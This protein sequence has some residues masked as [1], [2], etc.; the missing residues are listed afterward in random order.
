[1]KTQRHSRIGAGKLAQMGLLDDDAQRQAAELLD[2]VEADGLETVRLAFSDQHGILRGKT[3]V[4]SA[5][6]SAF[7]SGLGLPSTLLLK[8]TAHRTVFDV[9]SGRDDLDGLTLRGASDV[10]LVPDP[11]A[12]HKLDWA[13][14]SGLL[15]GDVVLRDGAPIP[16]A[17]RHVL[18]TAVERLAGTGHVAMMGLEVEFQVFERIDAR[19]DHGQATMPGAPVATRNTTQ[20]YQYLTETRYGEAEA[21]LDALRRAAEVMGLAPRSVEIEMGPSQY[22]FTFDASDPMEQADRFVLFRTMVK[23][24][25]HARGLHG[26]FMAKPGLPNAA[27]NGW[28]IHQSLVSA[29]DGVPAFM[30]EQDGIP[31]PAAEGWIAGLLEHAAASC[32][33][34]TP[35]VN[36]YKRYTPFQLAP[37]RIQ[38]GTDNRGAMIRALMF[39][40]DRAS[41]I[42]NRAPDSTANPHYALAAQILSGLDGL[43]RKAR[44]PA[45]TS[46]PYEGAALLPTSLGAAIDAFE[47]SPLFR[48]TLGEGFVSYLGH[49]KRAEWDRYLMTVSDWEQAEYFNLF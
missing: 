31:T 29:K 42:E 24:V 6:E 2:R 4:A 3:L 44:P 35:T 39:R 33:L 41:R 20:G 11:A 16:F 13:P 17:P 22:E 32:L 9:W 46:N 30:P 28:H 26:S 36:G 14:K 37:N 18:R 5:L 47:A 19:L 1:M 15:L 23:E 10:L 49:L 34:T 40:G 45:P 48:Q 27:A 7:V 8:D 43:Q 25:C 38:W 12:F 21:L